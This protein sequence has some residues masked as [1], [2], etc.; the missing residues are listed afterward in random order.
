MASAKSFP[1]ASVGTLVVVSMLLVA[2]LA[3]GFAW[4]VNFNRGREALAFYGPEAARLIRTAPKVEILVLAESTDAAAVANDWTE[5]GLPIER[6]IDISGARGLL[7]ARTSLLSDASY[8][9]ESDP[10]KQHFPYYIR[11]ADGPDDVVLAFGEPSGYI[12]GPRGVERL[13]QKTADGWREFIERNIKAANA[14]PTPPG[15]AR[16]APSE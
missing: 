15:P 13:N 2:A 14:R 8:E 10:P 1:A 12:Y 7:N 11:F 16:T 6:R 5:S 3:A 9:P 4:W